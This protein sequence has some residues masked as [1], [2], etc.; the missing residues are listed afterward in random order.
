MFGMAATIAEGSVLPMYTD[1][2]ALEHAALERRG[3]AEAE[4]AHER[5]LSLLPACPSRFVAFLRRIGAVRPAPVEDGAQAR[6]SYHQN[7]RPVPVR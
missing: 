4:A 5:R 7:A 1:I 3:R 6:P 2:Y